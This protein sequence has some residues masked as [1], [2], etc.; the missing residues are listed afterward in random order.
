MFFTQ[1]LYLK[2]AIDCCY[3]KMTIS[4]HPYSDKI[5][6]IIQHYKIFSMNNG[7]YLFNSKQLLR[8]SKSFR[9]QQ[10]NNHKKLY[11]ERT[12]FSNGGQH[13][14]KNELPFLEANRKISDLLVFHYIKIIHKKTPFLSLFCKL[15]L[16]RRTEI[17]RNWR[18]FCVFNT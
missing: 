16:S 11:I 8:A 10:K 13:Q 7:N 1:C 5:N 12:L 15:C 4:R 9:I 18:L 6:S 3:F 14:K 2:I 17:K